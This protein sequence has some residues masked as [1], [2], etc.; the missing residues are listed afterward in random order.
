MF[1]PTREVYS[2]DAVEAVRHLL[3]TSGSAFRH[4][5]LGAQASWAVPGEPN[6]MRLVIHDSPFISFVG[7]R[8]TGAH[9]SQISPSAH[10]SV[11]GAPTAARLPTVSCT[12][13]FKARFPSPGIHAHPSRPATTL[14][15]PS[16]GLQYQGRRQWRLGHEPTGQARS[17]PAPA[18]TSRDDEVSRQYT[19]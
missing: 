4:S 12:G 16:P 14:L 11:F 9:L 18:V 6:R 19:A 10:T 3:R 13:G 15:P 5:Y 17:I 7:A 1:R 2:G 8:F